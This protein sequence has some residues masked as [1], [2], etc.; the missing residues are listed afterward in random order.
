[1]QLFLTVGIHSIGCGT[2]GVNSIRTCPMSLSDLMIGWVYLCACPEW[3]CPVCMFGK[4]VVL[5][6]CWDG[7]CPVCMFG[8]VLFYVHVGMGVVLCACP[9][10]CCP[11]CMFG[12][13][14]VLCACWDGCCSVCMFGRVLLCVHV[15]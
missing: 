12:K 11:V 3:C 14:V 2:V 13:G 9:E 6:A 4:G 5:C 7:C 15:W 8:R 10:W 1:M